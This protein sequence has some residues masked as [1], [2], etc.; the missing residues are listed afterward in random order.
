MLLSDHT[1]LTSNGGV[2]SSQPG[3]TLNPAQTGS[4]LSATT[5]AIRP[6]PA[7]TS[8]PTPDLESKPLGL[9]L[10]PAEVDLDPVSLPSV[11]VRGQDK[12]NGAVV[13][14]KRGGRYLTDSQIEESATTFTGA[15]QDKIGKESESDQVESSRTTKDN[16]PHHPVSGALLNTRNEGTQESDGAS[17][18]H[19][20][21]RGHSDAPTAAPST[22]TGSSP[23]TAPKS[24]DTDVHPDIASMADVR[25]IPVTN[26]VAT[27]GVSQLDSADTLSSTLISPT[28]SLLLPPAKDSLSLKSDGS[29]NNTS[30]K[31]AE[32]SSNVTT[33][34]A[35]HQASSSSVPDPVSGTNSPP[36][37]DSGVLNSS[38][39]SN[40]TA[41][42]LDG[43][44]NPHEN[45]NQT[46]YKSDSHSLDTVNNT[47]ESYSA[48]PLNRNETS[49]QNASQ[50]DTN[51][52]RNGNQTS[53]G[54]HSGSE[55]KGLPL[56]AQQKERSVFLRLSNHMEELDSNMTL[57]SIFLDQISSR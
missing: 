40:G 36:N 23:L 30:Q 3:S 16:D 12:E 24:I 38:C 28:P 10:G 22:S 29:A 18:E 31:T 1:S 39:S 33:D 49:H 21:E 32:E 20:V 11:E 13:E 57:F 9:D 25:H 43:S 52:T 42:N 46:D 56:P 55:Y 7:S 48:S 14:E 37:S 27:Y 19:S 17:S 2:A 41:C 35:N 50:L 5:N 8:N 34:C 53:N 54:L 51:V 44:E 47:N 15:G 26:S 6:T 4:T 45:G